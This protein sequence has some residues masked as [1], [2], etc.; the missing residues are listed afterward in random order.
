MLLICP[1][2][3]TTLFWRELVLS[4]SGERGMF[5]NPTEDLEVALPSANFTSRPAL[6]LVKVFF[7][8]EGETGEGKKF[9]CK[10][11]SL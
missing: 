6:M 7:L 4:H 2:P 1:V 10:H 8:A 5:G 9:L 11:N 3:V